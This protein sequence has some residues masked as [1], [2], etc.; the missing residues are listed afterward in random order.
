VCGAYEGGLT[1][2]CPGEKVDFDKQQEVYET[3]LDYT[4]DRGW[5]LG[6]SMKQRSPRF[7]DTRRAPEPPR[8]DPRATIAP[9]I[10]WTTVD[11]HTRLQHE[12]TQR[13]ITW[14]IAERIC[15]DQSARLTRL[16]DE[17][18]ALLMQ[19]PPSTAHELRATLERE[20]SAWKLTCHHVDRCDE[21]FRQAARTIVDALE[22][23]TPIKGARNTAGE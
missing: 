19:Q 23:V 11:R 8:V 21:E 6:E 2:D 22:T 14:A 10:D 13:A 20:K 3:T 17:I 18:D 5:H 1:T 16:E 15:A 7:T 4:D 12:L 9:S